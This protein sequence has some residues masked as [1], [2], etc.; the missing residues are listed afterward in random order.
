MSKPIPI[1]HY[2]ATSYKM[3]YFLDGQV[4][5]ILMVLTA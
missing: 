1:F 5:D 4:L 3:I 2:K